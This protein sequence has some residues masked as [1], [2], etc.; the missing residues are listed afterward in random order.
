MKQATH[1][2]P[3]EGSTLRIHVCDWGGFVVSTGHEDGFRIGGQAAFATAD[4]CAD[5]LRGFLRNSAAKKFG[6]AKKDAK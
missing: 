3:N 2:Q 1:V 6:A 4:H 5:W